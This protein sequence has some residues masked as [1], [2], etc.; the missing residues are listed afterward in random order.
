MAFTGLG[1]GA[2]AFFRSLTINQEKSWF[3]AHKDEYERQV[4]APMKAL[5]SDLAEALARKK[6]PLT[7][8]PAR[9][10]FRIHR[11]VRFAKDKQPYK[12]HAAAVLTRDGRKW[13]PGLLYIHVDPLGSFLAA[14]FYRL[15]PE[16]LSCVR[17]AILTE[18]KKFLAMEKKLHAKGL[19]LSREEA[20]ARL[21]RGFEEAA[22]HPAPWALKQKHFTVRRALTE[23]EL[24]QPS[25]INKI[26]AFAGE[27]MPL[28]K[29]GWEAVDV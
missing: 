12:T 4:Q 3:T 20:L 9:A 25:L 13:N 5:V 18:P 1:P 15:E 29:F 7:G 27:A 24:G 8:D 2:L 6:L 26:V 23:A 10:L 22:N 17:E 28:L 16:P 11:D 19:E 14:G 21:P